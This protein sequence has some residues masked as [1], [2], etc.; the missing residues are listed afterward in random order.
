[1]NPS[2]AEEHIKR[3]DISIRANKEIWKAAEHTVP[4]AFHS[5][6]SKINQLFDLL[7][8]ESTVEFSRRNILLSHY[9]MKLVFKFQ[10][11]I[12]DNL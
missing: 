7:E 11:E 8:R 2:D 5:H 4:A 6:L 1:M 3:V 9:S 10:K 12:L